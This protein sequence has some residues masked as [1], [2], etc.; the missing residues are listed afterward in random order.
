MV[1]EQITEQWNH[2][3]HCGCVVIGQTFANNYHED[4]WGKWDELSESLRDRIKQI[5]LGN[6]VNMSGNI[7]GY[8]SDNQLKYIQYKNIGGN[9]FIEDDAGQ[10]KVDF[11]AMCDV[12]NSILMSAVCPIE[13]WYEYRKELLDCSITL[14]PITYNKFLDGIVST[15]QPYTEVPYTSPGNFVFTVPAFT[16][17]LRYAICGGGGGCLGRGE[18][19]A[20]TNNAGGSAIA[21]ISVGGATG[22]QLFVDVDTVPQPGYP[23]GRSGIQM[24]QRDYPYYGY[25][26]QGATGWALNFN[27]EAGVYGKGGNGRTYGWGSPGGYGWLVSGCSGGYA[28]GYI[29]V[30]PGQQISLTVGGG[31]SGY[32]RGDGGPNNVDGGHS[33]FVLIAYGVGIY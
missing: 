20:Q 18:Y 19:Y 4:K 2:E 16:Y 7:I 31:S 10:I 13:I 11:G 15:P 21:G 17:K 9:I 1:E 27:G 33:G 8:A 25:E 30:S 3:F 14:T 29:N 24:R 32:W 6:S 5:Q 26:V 12:M 22:G 28:T 23:N